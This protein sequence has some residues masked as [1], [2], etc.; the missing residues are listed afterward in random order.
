M[1]LGFFSFQ[2][3]NLFQDRTR[4]SNIEPEKCTAKR[5]LD[6]NRRIFGGICEVREPDVYKIAKSAGVR[7]ADFKFL[8]AGQRGQEFF[9]M[10]ISAR[11]EQHVFSGAADQTR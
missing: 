6:R 5:V 2:C 10:R 4:T 11:Q 3:T 1:A 9:L 7:T 8:D